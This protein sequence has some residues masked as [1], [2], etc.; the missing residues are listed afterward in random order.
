MMNIRR[1][2]DLSAIEICPELDPLLVYKE[3]R[4]RFDEAGNKEYLY[5]N[6]LGEELRGSTPVAGR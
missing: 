4:R 2:E 5:I 6:G 1:E 3:A